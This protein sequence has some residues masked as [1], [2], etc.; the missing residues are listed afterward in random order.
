MRPYAEAEFQGRG[1]RGGARAHEAASHGCERRS[2]LGAMLAA[3]FRA[4]RRG[5]PAGAGLS[6]RGYGPP[7]V[8]LSVL[9]ATHAA[10]S[11]AALKGRKEAVQM[12]SQQRERE[13]RAD[14]VLY[15][16]IGPGVAH[17]SYAMAGGESRWRR[18]PPT[19]RALR[20]R[21]K[22]RAK[23]THQRWRA[24]PLCRRSRLRVS[25]RWTTMRTR[26]FR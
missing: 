3:A 4:S 15:R 20:L 21:A 9:A 16:R 1:A 23:G 2:G 6:L 24:P 22:R 18:S 14:N 8:A 19:P 25:Y 13:E 12:R 5:C 11:G 26:D 7:A 10:I 17:M